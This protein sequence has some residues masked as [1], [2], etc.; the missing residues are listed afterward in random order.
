MRICLRVMTDE[1]GRVTVVDDDGRE[2]AGVHSVK[3]E[4]GAAGGMKMTLEVACMK[5]G[6][7]LIAR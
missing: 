6:K 5:D 3:V 7:R 1:S 4:V 2:V